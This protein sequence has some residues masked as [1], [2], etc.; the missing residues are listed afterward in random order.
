MGEGEARLLAE[1]LLAA[2][3]PRRWRH[4]QAVAAE[5]ARLCE[6]LTIARGS[7]I[8]AAWLHDIGYAP[9][10][11]V[12]GFHPLDGAR[13]L[14]THGWDDEVCRLVAHHS[15]ATH[16]A[17]PAGVGGQLRAEFAEIGGPAR[18][19]LWAA[20]ATTG[21]NGERFSLDERISEISDRYGVDHQVTRAMAASRDALAGAIARVT[22]MS[23]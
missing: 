21:P 3:L 12:T 15:D 13:Y 7:V 19:I 2:A 20:D 11:A 17:D 5:A 4:V 16:Q 22:A 1:R 6:G 8:A 9:T 23:H 18:D 14:R 10:V